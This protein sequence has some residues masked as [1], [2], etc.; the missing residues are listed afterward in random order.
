[1]TARRLKRLLK[2]P[3]ARL[4][5][6]RWRWSSRQ[7]GLALCYHRVSDPG[8]DPARDLV[9]ALDTKGFEAHVRYLKRRWRPVL[10]S[11]LLEAARA[12]RR[13]ERFP[14]A[15]TFDDDLASHVDGAMPVL[16]R[17]GAPATFFLCG[18]S[19]ERPFGFWW[20]RLQR[21]WDSGTVDKGMLRTLGAE[22]GD[23]EPATIDR[24]SAAIQ[25]L[26]PDRRRALAEELA[27]H[28]GPDPPDSGIRAPDVGR[29]VAADFEIGF[30][31]LHH[32][33]LTGLDDAAL[34]A[35][36]VE[37]REELER[38]AG[39]PIAAISYPY[40]KVDR[41]VAEAARAAQYRWGFTSSGEAVGPNSDPLM[42]GRHDPGVGT[43][44]D[45][46]LALAR[47]LRDGRVS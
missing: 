21:A 5:E 12:R 11:E 29:L 6:L 31:T 1:M 32:D 41:R 35:A 43:V 7:A 17:H 40:G 2:G 16:E 18:A 47:R 30:H 20:E 10:A 26:P 36:M 45:L 13:G 27:T 4:I 23:S 28:A 44:G 37:G 14:V 34:A 19:L 24:V 46:A 9:P 38:A 3:A 15:I 22:D 42:L 33:A 25:E 8:G 39:A